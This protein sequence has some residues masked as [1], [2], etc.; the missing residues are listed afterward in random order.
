MLLVKS[1]AGLVTEL[2]ADVFSE[3]YADAITL[4]KMAI[5]NGELVTISSDPAYADLNPL[6]ADQTLVCIQKL[7]RGE[8]LEV[9]HANTAYYEKAVKFSSRREN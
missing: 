3:S 8:R 9:D 2:N 5:H 7:L 1:L 6:S 4:E